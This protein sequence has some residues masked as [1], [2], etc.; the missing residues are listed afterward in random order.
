MKHLLFA[1]CLA[2]S[3]SAFA[4][5]GGFT[6]DDMAV[7]ARV[8][9]EDG[10][11][12]TARELAAATD[13]LRA[14]FVLNPETAWT[15]LSSDERAVLQSALGPDA[16]NR[17]VELAWLM[18]GAA[19]RVGDLAA[20][21][22][23]ALY[24]PVGD[25]WLLLGWARVSGEWR[26]ANAALVPGAR[27]RLGD[28]T[29][30]WTVQPGYYLTALASSHDQAL[31]R[32]VALTRNSS[33][34]ELFLALVPTRT[35]DRAAV[36][37]RAGQWL[38]SLAGWKRDPDRAAAYVHLRAMLA[39]GG[40]SA[41]PVANFPAPVRASLTPLGAITYE[42]GTSL[43]MASPLFPE[44]TIAA[45]FDVGGGNFKSLSVTNLAQAR[46]TGQ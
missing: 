27:L 40:K 35:G 7:A 38:N 25:G 30:D 46:G 8:G 45:E 39:E 43:L 26:L 37:E 15:I 44:I 2:V 29:G 31:D 32:F 9:Q 6:A 10:A 24:N 5:P 4:A 13:T 16:I 11:I 41:G 18:R 17:A 36:Y 20:G 21:P 14:A 22:M 19:V 33:A 1:V 23:T 34:R 12:A 42:G 3:T 28:E